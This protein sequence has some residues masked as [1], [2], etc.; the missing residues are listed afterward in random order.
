MLHLSGI[1]YERLTFNH[2]GKRFRLT[3]VEGKVRKGIFFENT[4]CKGGINYV[5]YQF[6]QVKA[7]LIAMNNKHENYFSYH[8]SQVKADL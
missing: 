6:S 7:D 2:P 4:P 8:Y 3:D 1:D 5:L